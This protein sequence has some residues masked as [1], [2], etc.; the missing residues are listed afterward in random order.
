MERNGRRQ[1]TLGEF[2]LLTSAGHF[3]GGESNSRPRCATFDDSGPLGPLSLE[4]NPA[5]ELLALDG[6]ERLLRAAKFARIEL[7]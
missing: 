4:Q 5:D 6:I 1:L 3:Q 2:I 7:F